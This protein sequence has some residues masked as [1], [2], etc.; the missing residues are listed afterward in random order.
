MSDLTVW[1]DGYGL[2]HCTLP[3]RQEALARRA[4]ARSAIVAELRL[5]EGPAFDPASVR[6][7]L[8]ETSDGLAH[9]QEID[10]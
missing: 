3:V 1:A 2:W 9:Y 4:R 6:I 7:Q 10:D 8:V 5:R